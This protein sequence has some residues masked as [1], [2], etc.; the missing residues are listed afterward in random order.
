MRRYQ[1]M[2]AVAGISATVWLRM[3]DILAIAADRG[4]SLA[5]DL[6]KLPTDCLQ[7]HQKQKSPT[8]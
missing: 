4:H 3:G 2:R 5:L 7:P 6:D 8:L 1:P